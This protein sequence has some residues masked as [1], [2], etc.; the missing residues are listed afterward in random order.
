MVNTSLTKTSS[1]LLL[2]LI[3]LVS[4]RTENSQSHK[5][6]KETTTFNK[7]PSAYMISFGGKSAPIHITEYFSFSCPKF[8]Q[9]I[10]RDFPV[11]QSNYIDTGK[12]H[13]IFHP[14]PADI[15]TLQAM[16]CFERLEE[17][18][19]QCILENLSKEIRDRSMKKAV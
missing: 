19:K 11:I 12:I 5:N 9:F 7:L 8:L 4:H 14:D 13:W 17:P 2:I 3:L 1:N 18:E 16:V 6:N 10:R 15:L